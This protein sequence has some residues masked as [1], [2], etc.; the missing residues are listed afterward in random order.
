MLK[1]ARIFIVGHQ[2]AVENALVVGLKA[3]GFTRVYANTKDRIDVLS[4][5]KT[6]AFFKDIKPEFVFLGS[7]RSGGIAANLKMPAEFMYENIQAQNN[8]I[9]AAYTHKAKK[10]LYYSGSCAYPAF[11]KQPIKEESLLTG[12]LEASSEPYSVAKIAGVKMCQAYRCQYGFNAI[13]AV[14]ATLYGPG[15]DDDLATAHVMGSLIAKFTSAVKHG[16]KSVAVWGTGKPRR[17]FLY[18][19]DFVEA[20]LML[21]RAYDEA[22]LINMGCGEDITIRELAGLIARLSGYKGKV[23]FDP[24]KPDGTKR[25]LMDNARI[26]KLGWKPKVGLE[27]GIRKTMEWYRHA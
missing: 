23:T 6:T 20:S 8:V 10:L 12:S 19:D 22:G 21:M 14:P 1:N 11:A 15:S 25:K 2:D 13:A 17:E 9:H 16:E 27:E 4:Q 24:T 18:V 7:I 3:R 26:R 5:A